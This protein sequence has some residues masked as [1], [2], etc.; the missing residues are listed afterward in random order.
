[1]CRCLFYIFTLG[2][3]FIFFSWYLFHSIF[4]FQSLDASLRL[5]QLEAERQHLDTEL[6]A[7]CE[8]VKRAEEAQLLLETQIVARPLRGGDKIRRTQSFIPTT[9]ERPLLEK[10]E[11]NRPMTLQKN[12]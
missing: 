11:N 7:A 10:L 1:M 2:F 12:L 8:K 5:Q 9:K 4:L 6:R 3:N